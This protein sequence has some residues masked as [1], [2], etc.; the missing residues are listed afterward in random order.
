M[1]GTLTA[2]ASFVKVPCLM[3]GLGLSAEFF[4]FEARGSRDGLS[5]VLE[6][7]AVV[8]PCGGDDFCIFG[9]GGVFLVG[10]LLAWG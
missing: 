3:G 2:E 9:L 10:V 7:L 1:N 4:L 6:T 5:L 8:L